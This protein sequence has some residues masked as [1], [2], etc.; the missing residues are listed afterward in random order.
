MSTQT[1]LKIAKQ[2]SY[3][4]VKVEVNPLLYSYR[5]LG[6]LLTDQSGQSYEALGAVINLTC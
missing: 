2:G 5:E 4:A 3:A 6:L 1:R